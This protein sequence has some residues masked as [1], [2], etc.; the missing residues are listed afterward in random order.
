MYELNLIV[1]LQ[2]I[3][4]FSLHN[5]RNNISTTIFMQHTVIVKNVF[6]AFKITFNLK[7]LMK[8]VKKQKI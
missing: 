6:I 7:N 3:L 2:Q 5:F 8:A 1:S 4:R